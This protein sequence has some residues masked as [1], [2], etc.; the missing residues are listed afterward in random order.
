M[1]RGY[2]RPEKERDMQDREEAQP[3]VIP[4]IPDMTGSEKEIAQESC[5]SVKDTPQDNAEQTGQVS[6]TKDRKS[7]C[8]RKYLQTIRHSKFTSELCR[9]Y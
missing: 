1:P 7:L 5:E 8:I 9:K 2:S 4:F 6:D 3:L